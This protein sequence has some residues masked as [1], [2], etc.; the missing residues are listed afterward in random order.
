[1]IKI[2]PNLPPWPRIFAMADLAPTS[3]PIAFDGLDTAIAEAAQAERL[4]RRMERCFAFDAGARELSI[5]DEMFAFTF[6]LQAF[7]QE[8]TALNGEPVTV[9]INSPGGDAF[10]GIAIYNALVRYPGEVTVRIDGIA[11]SAASL[12][13]MAGDRIVVPENGFIMVHNPA[14]IAAGTDADF[15]RVAD[16]LEKVREAYAQTYAKRT[17]AEQT[18]VQAFMDGETYFTAQQAKNNGFATEIA[19]P[20]RI[21]AFDAAR[22]PG[23][24]PTALLEALTPT[25]EDP[26]ANPAPA[27]PEPAPAAPAP[28]APDPAPAPAPS[29][30]PP[31]TMS[32]QERAGII[33]DLCALASCPERAAEFIASDQ[34]L[35]RI[36]A[37]IRA[38]KPRAP[39]RLPDNRLPSPTSG[40]LTASINPVEA[41]AKW[42][43]RGRGA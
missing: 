15:R 30:P 16:N 37:A 40:Q 43:K 17:G 28:P 10:L 9:S 20:I 13:A 24:P 11:A 4:S 33:A 38:F 18:A 22:L 3:A 41:W 36:R 6:D 42:N 27:P 26:P 7:V 14:S 8:L 19:P 12:V 1:M 32:A 2:Q 34:P 39:Q 29:Q 21:G 35:D 31:A 5:H 23:K 25:A